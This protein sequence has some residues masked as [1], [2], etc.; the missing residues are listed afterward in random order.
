MVLLLVAALVAGVVVVRDSFPQTDGEL[1]LPG[2][3]GSV[4]V[5]RDGNGIPQV[6]AGTSHDLF[7]AQGF[8]QAQDRFFE[9]DV[10]RHTTAGRLSEM[11]G[12]DTLEIDKTIRTMGWRRVA[13]QELAQLSPESQAY[14]QAYADG[15]NAY[16]HEHSPSEMSLEY[17]LLSRTGLDYKV[18]DWTPADSVAWL[19]AMA[20]DLRGNMDDEIQR[21]LMSASHTPEEI[22]EL[23]PSYP[24]DRHR[25]IVERGGVVD[26]VFEQDATSSGTRKPSRPPLDPAA[27]RSLAQVHRV[28]RGMPAMLGKGDGIGSNAWV[29]DGNHSTTGKPILA[30]DPHLGVSV[31]GIWYQMGLHCTQ[32]SEECPFDV[33]GFTF[34]GLPGVV[35]GHNK[36]IAWGFTN[37]GPD[38]VDLYLEKV[39]GKTYLYDGRQQPLRMRDE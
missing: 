4:K 32:L 35:I 11:F 21:G 3:D 18:E 16:L 34:S 31:P 29:V 33:A 24:Y 2:L 12:E 28:L 13:E 7:F 37:L 23:F 30:N 25:P 6:Y 39:E 38:V 22:A 1:A 9:M 8:V 14:L 36:K 5:L 26:G 20:W 10:R 15:V 19:K 17:T 27:E